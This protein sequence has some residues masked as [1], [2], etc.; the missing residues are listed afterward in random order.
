MM[1]TLPANDF[2]KMNLSISILM[3]I[4]GSIQIAR[5]MKVTT[6]LVLSTPFLTYLWLIYFY[7]N[8]YYILLVSA[9]FYALITHKEYVK[10]CKE[11]QFIADDAA[12]IAVNVDQAQRA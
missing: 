12:D 3:V 2:L 9:L 7:Q 10:L 5:R 4:Y 8:I 11:T 1:S 6:L